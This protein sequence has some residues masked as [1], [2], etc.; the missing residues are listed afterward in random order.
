MVTLGVEGVNLGIYLWCNFRQFYIM[1][2][3]CGNFLRNTI[4]PVSITI[5][6]G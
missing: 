5:N 2:L 3:T 6:D 1:E 4:D